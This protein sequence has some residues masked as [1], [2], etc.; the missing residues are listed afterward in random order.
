MNQVEVMETVTK[1][2]MVH[3]GQ[4]DNIIKM[5]YGMQIMIGILLAK[6]TTAIIQNLLEQQTAVYGKLKLVQ[7]FIT[8]L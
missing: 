6:I 8:Y 2:I 1:S 7:E 4:Q 5:E 3:S